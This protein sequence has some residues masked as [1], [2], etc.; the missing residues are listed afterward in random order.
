MVILVRTDIQMGKGKIASQCAHAAVCLYK[1]ASES[2][3]QNVESWIFS[4]QPKIILKVNEN[5][6][7]RILEV[8]KKAKKRGLNA[9]LI[10]DG[11][12]TQVKGGT[13]TCLGIGPSCTKEIDDLTNCFKLL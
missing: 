5:S 2:G 13:L 11:G 12:R 6:E 7:D 10:Y 1:S 9:C 8:Y 4:G 3:P